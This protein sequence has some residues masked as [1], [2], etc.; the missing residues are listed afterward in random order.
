MDT[1]SAWLEHKRTLPWNQLNFSLPAKL[2]RWAAD[3]PLDFRAV[4]PNE[5]YARLGAIAY[6]TIFL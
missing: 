6:H 2:D 1:R 5:P 4:H 3:C